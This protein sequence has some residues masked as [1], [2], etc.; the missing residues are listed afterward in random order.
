MGLLTPV[1]HCFLCVCL[2]DI[3]AAHHDKISS[4]PSLPV[5]L[6]IGSDEILEVV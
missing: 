3:T 1:R 4:A 2:T 5:Y 6:Y